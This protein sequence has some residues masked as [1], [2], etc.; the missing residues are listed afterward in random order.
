MVSFTRSIDLALR[1]LLFSKF[2][3]V[4]GIDQSGTSVENINKG[5][6]Q[7]PK[8]IALREIAE[9]RG[10][11]FLEF[12]NFWRM[13]TSPSMGRQRTS[14]AR[15]GFYVADTTSDKTDIKNVKAIPVD[16]NYNVW[17]WSKSLDKVYQ[18]IEEYLF[19]QQDNPNLTLSY[20]TDYALEFDLHFGEIVDESS[21]EEKYSS[22]IIF[23]Y[24]LPIKIEGWIFKS[25]TSKV[26]QKIILT[27]YNKDDVD[28]YSE[29][30]VE[31]SNQDTELTS[32][33]KM[34]R[35]KLYGILEITSPSTIT[36]PGNFASDFN[37]GDKIVWENS[38]SNNGIYTIV[39]VIDVGNNT[40]IVVSESIPSDV[41]IG[42]IYKREL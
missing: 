40:D 5:I 15:R 9:K 12:M 6:V 24:K 42:N 4:L 19:W 26:I 31:D 30:V 22:G 8:E 13:G 17:F 29:I 33:L 10:E 20:D 34:F 41:V 37:V 23:V 18:C 35:E 36:I 11:D 14:V 25:S 16:L 28:D 2:A 3:G 27:E 21:I 1:A 7:T 38:T 32:I 39:S